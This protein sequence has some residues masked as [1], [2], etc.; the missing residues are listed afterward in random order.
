MQITVSLKLD[1]PATAS[2]PDLELLVQEAGQRAMRMALGEVVR[3]YEAQHRTCAH[4]GSTLVHGEGTDRRVLRTLFG[5]VVLAPRRLR[6]QGCGR[7][8]RPAEGCLAALK[9]QQVTPALA[10]AAAQAGAAW[11]YA[12]A[13]RELA[14]L[15][16]ASISP[17][18]VR[19]LTIQQGTQEAR[20]QAQKAAALVE[21][22][23]AGV[24]AERDHERLCPVRSTPPALLVVGL[25]GGWVPCREQK[26]GMEGKVGVV[27][28]GTERIGKQRQRLTPRCY[29][30]TFANSEQVGK[31]TYAAACGLG[32]EEAEVQVVLGDGANWIKSEAALHFPEAVTI[33]D[34][35]HLWRVVQAAVRAARPGPTWRAVRRECYQALTQALWHGQVDVAQA[36]LQALRPGPL[37][38]PVEALEAALT[39]LENQRAWIGD[40]QHWRELGYPVGSGLV[41]RAVAL[42]INRRLKRQGMRWRR[43]NATAVV[44]LRVRTINADW[45]VASAQRHRAA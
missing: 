34:W 45:K 7:R 4:C 28:S 3:A 6:C 25:D 19:Q 29:V 13:A 43:A 41:E 8:F 32:A 1:V 20:Q 27:V 22:T 35:P 38:V 5:R 30:A 9:G 17:E 18:Q 23:A 21:P 40:Y 11:P 26:G 39:Y 16:G 10:R 44:A 15:C 2:I 31:L 24:R 33:L 12:I 42:I 14:Q 36:Q 37:D